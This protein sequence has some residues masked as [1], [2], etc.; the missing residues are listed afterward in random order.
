MG[1]TPTVTETY[2]RGR[3]VVKV[4]FTPRD[5]YVAWSRR[6]KKIAWSLLSDY[7]REVS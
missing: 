3:H 5:Y 7:M 1:I 4:H 6:S 2:E